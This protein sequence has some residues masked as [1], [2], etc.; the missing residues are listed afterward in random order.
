MHE[1]LHPAEKF[2]QTVL[3][4]GQPVTASQIEHLFGLLPTNVADRF[5][6]QGGQTFVSGIY[7][8]GGVVG[9]TTTCRNLPLSTMLLIKWATA[10][11]DSDFT[12]CSLVLNLNVKTQVHRDGN[13][14][15]ADNYVLPVSKFVNGHM[16]VESPG[17]LTASTS[18][19]SRC[20]GFFMMLPAARCVSSLKVN[21]IVQCRGWASA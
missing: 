4:S 6:S 19:A 20:Q 15:D 14:D 7:R 12:F 1:S 21:F 13:N 11:C 3:S 18:M 2:A 17:D 5:G 9:L 10:S 16:W 8:H